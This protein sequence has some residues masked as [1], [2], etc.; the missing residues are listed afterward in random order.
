ML[1]FLLFPAGAVFC[2]WDQDFYSRQAAASAPHHAAASSAG[3]YLQLSSVLS[4]LSE[5]LQQLMGLNLKQQQI[6]SR[7]GWG[8]GEGG[9]S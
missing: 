3:P 9:V 1:V 5:L 8:P 2:P 4:G 6:G 7:E